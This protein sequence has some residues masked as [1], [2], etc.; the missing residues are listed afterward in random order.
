MGYGGNRFRDSVRMAANSASQLGWEAQPF[1]AQVFMLRV[2]FR[3]R[4]LGAMD[5]KRLR[6]A[7]AWW[8]Y[9]SQV[10]GQPAPGGWTAGRVDL[11]NGRGG[12]R[13]S[14]LALCPGANLY[15]EV[16]VCY[17]GWRMGMSESARAPC[18]LMQQA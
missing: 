10:W 2:R 12:D 4:P 9:W 17:R 1:R 15:S 5:S 7:C 18:S 6:T 11:R 8:R 14:D 13:C 3:V 16:H